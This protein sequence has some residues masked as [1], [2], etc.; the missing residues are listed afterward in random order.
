MK[1]YY[2]PGAC[3]LAPHIVLNEL[4]LPYEAVQVD[5]KSH[6]L[7]ANGADYFAINPKGYVPAI[8]LDDGSLLTEGV[9]ILQYLADLKPE[10]G[11][12]AKPGSMERLHT[13][14]WLTFISSELHKSFSP[15]WNAAMP[16]AAKQIFLDKLKTRFALLEKHLAGNA[17]LMGSRFTV[18]DAY[19]YTILNWSAILKIDMHPWP[20]VQAYLQRVAERVKVRETRQAEKL[21][22]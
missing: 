1:L 19:A 8:E 7:A 18:A 9:A 3:S 15:L 20:A 5:T 21:A 22:A 10:A 6:T 13:I 2:S 4:G 14:E 16:E 17:F 11:L 12:L